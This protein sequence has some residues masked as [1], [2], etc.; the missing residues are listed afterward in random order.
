LRAL[1]GTSSDCYTFVQDTENRLALEQKYQESRITADIAD[2]KQFIQ[3][4]FGDMKEDIA[5]IKTQMKEDIAEIKTQMKGDI[6][7]ITTQMKGDI[8]EIKT[9]MKG[10]IAEIKKIRLPYGQISR[11]IRGFKV[12]ILKIRNVRFKPYILRKKGDM[13]LDG[14]WQSEKYFAAYSDHIRSDFTFRPDFSEF[15]REIAEEISTRNAVSIHIRRGDYI[16][17]KTNLAIYGSCSIGYY[18]NA[19]A[20][21]TNAANIGYADGFFTAVETSGTYTEAGIFSNGT[22]TVNSGILVSHVAIAITKSTSE[23]LTVSWTLTI[24]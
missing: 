6:A 15:N 12:R 21:I 4:Q 5:E 14:F 24:S 19:I 22:A 1:N 8:A 9:Q 10:D 18:R 7:E 3:T 16:K 23:T 13:Y 17:N 11:Y 2:L 20:Y